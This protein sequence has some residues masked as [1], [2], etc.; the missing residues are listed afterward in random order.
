M[1][2][3]DPISARAARAANREADRIVAERAERNRRIVELHLER[4]LSERA[5]ARELDCS[6]STVWNVLQAAHREAGLE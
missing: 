4:G 5:I 6:R 3:T 2:T 1:A